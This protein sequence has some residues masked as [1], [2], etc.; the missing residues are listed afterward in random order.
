MVLVAETGAVASVDGGTNRPY[1]PLHVLEIHFFARHEVATMK[2]SR[3]MP[4][5]PIFRPRA[6]LIIAG[7][8][9]FMN[10]CVTTAVYVDKTHVARRSQLSRDLSVEDADRVI[11]RIPGYEDFDLS[12]FPDGNG[13]AGSLQVR[14]L[15]ASGHYDI[16]VVYAGLWHGRYRVSGEHAPDL[17]IALATLAGDDTILRTVPED[18]KPFGSREGVIK[19][20]A[21]PPPPARRVNVAVAPL[22]ALGLAET[23]VLTLADHLRTALVD[24]EYFNVVSRGDMKRVLIEQSM[25]RDDCT[26]ARCLVELG[27]LLAVEKMVGGT[28]GKVGAT[29]NITL[30]L[31]DVETAKIEVS[32]V[33]SVR[34]EPDALLKTI[35]ALGQKLTAK[36]DAR[37]K[38]EK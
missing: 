13:R 8:A 24:T 36:Y 31:V 12:F 26:D 32:V 34:G 15:P 5:A 33:D 28:V 25:Q 10:A 4:A 21:L 38:S 19:E 30:R 16:G 18:I 29:F 17:L 2:H 22:A 11:R 37:R 35:W 27:K 1:A 3:T 9:L 14:H 20:L 7:L 23:E 6:W